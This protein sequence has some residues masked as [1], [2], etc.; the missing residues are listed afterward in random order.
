MRAAAVGLSTSWSGA[1]AR[2]ARRAPYTS[3]NPPS[4]P[5]TC[6]DHHLVFDVHCLSP[7]SLHVSRRAS[8][9]GTSACP[10]TRGPHHTLVSDALLCAP[11]LLLIA[12]C[13]YG[14]STDR[15]GRQ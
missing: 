7:P 14:L 1:M 8:V 9:A 15:R 13:R 2:G 11:A 5:N 10:A 12:A 3:V 4:M 6:D